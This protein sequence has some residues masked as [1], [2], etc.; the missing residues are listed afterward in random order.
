M[1]HKSVEAPEILSH[2]HTSGVA[3]DLIDTAGDHAAHEPPLIP[4]QT[5]E[6]MNEHGHPE[7]GQKRGV[8]GQVRDVGIGAELGTADVEGTVC[9]W[10]EGAIVTVIGVVGDI[11]KW[12][13]LW[14][15]AMKVGHGCWSVPLAN[16]RQSLAG[17]G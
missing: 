4:Y 8:G 7:H 13:R 16:I 5:D 11:T 10:A 6:D 17:Q 15:Q 9:I 1:D 3:Q 12:W 2:P 14:I